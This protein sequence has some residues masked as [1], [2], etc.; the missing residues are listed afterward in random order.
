MYSQ[1]NPILQ[2]YKQPLFRR[3][4]DNPTFERTEVNR[5]CGD[6]I[7]LYVS[8]DSSDHTEHTDQLT[9]SHPGQSVAKTKTDVPL[10]KLYQNSIVTQV[11]FQGEGCSLSLSSAELLCRLVSGKTGF[12]AVSLARSFLDFLKTDPSVHMPDHIPVEFGFYNELR[13]Y[14]MRQK[15]AS[16]AWEIL[17]SMFASASDF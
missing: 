15:C 10:N 3:T 2:L 16:M 6:S 14:P 1:D 12:E 7:T 17:I 8:I 5:S 11:S 9:N 4:L 13:S